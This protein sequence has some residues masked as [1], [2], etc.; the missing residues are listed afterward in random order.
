MRRKARTDDN[1]TDVV[2]ALRSIPGV[3]VELNHHDFLIGFRGQTYWI[4]WKSQNAVKKSG[5]LKKN[6]LRDSQKK[7]IEKWT[8]Q[9]LV[10][11]TLD[12]I[13]TEIGVTK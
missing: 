3:T 13:L 2:K 11:W 1:Q 6:A 5:G 10:A 4:E 7:I 8:G 12:Q 9:Y